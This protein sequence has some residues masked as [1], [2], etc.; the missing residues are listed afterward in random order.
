MNLIGKWS[1][2]RYMGPKRWT[3][4][5][6]LISSCCS[7]A[8][9]LSKWLEKWQ[10]LIRTS[11]P[12]SILDKN[13]SKLDKAQSAKS[14]QPAQNHTI[15]ATQHNLLGLHRD[16][17]MNKQWLLC[18]RAMERSSAP[19]LA[20]D[21]GSHCCVPLI[22][23]WWCGYCYRSDVN[24]THCTVVASS[25]PVVQLLHAV[26]SALLGVWHN[27]FADVRTPRH[28]EHFFPY[29]R[30]CWVELQTGHL[31]FNKCFY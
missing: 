5:S 7:V 25:L 23:H 31:A 21:Q 28:W 11:F 10:H 15:V 26:I 12:D 18:S 17:G 14:A 16:N 4:P 30:Y 8:D 19:L 1:A 29:Y 2:L 22:W 9:Y 27:N 24:T 6:S 20:G 13:T 3:G